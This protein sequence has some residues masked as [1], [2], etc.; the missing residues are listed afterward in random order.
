VNKALADMVADGT[1]ER[2]TK[3]LVG[4]SPAPK[5]PIRSQI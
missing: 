4:F 2:L 3:E 1:Y 5:S